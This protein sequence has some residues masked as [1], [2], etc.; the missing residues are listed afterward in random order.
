MAY[1][2]RMDAVQ[3]LRTRLAEECGWV[4]EE[5]GAALVKA[6]QADARRADVDGHSRSLMLELL[7]LLQTSP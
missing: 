2:A 3:E 7:Q 6:L 4:Y 5:Q 1:T